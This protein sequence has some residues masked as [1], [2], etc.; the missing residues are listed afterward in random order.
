MCDDGIAHLWG[1]VD[2]DITLLEYFTER[3]PQKTTINKK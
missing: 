2:M 1:I 3:K